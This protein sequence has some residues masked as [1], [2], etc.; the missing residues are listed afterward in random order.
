VLALL[1][2]L[3]VRDQPL[4]RKQSADLSWPGK[5][6]ERR[7]TSLSWLLHQLNDRLPECQ[8]A[9]RYAVQFKR[10]LPLHTARVFPFSRG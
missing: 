2:Y 4:V 8:E 1:G 3:V 6:V 10:E 7:W 9:G 5:P